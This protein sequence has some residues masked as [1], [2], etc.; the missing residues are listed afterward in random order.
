VA[1][2][3]E[4]V[5]LASLFSGFEDPIRSRLRRRWHDGERYSGREQDD[6]DGGNVGSRGQNER[7]P[8]VSVL[9]L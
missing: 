4:K 2:L 5:V 8:Q 9:A 6:E 7:H 1:G 3:E